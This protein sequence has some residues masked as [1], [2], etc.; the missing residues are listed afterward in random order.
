MN[1]SPEMNARCVTYT[2]L[3]I[4]F[5]HMGLPSAS[6]S[7]NMVHHTDGRRKKDLGRPQAGGREGNAILLLK[8]QTA[9]T[10][11][12]SACSLRRCPRA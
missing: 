10:K 4:C 2:S 12:L 6:D 3:T 1:K 5:I 11:E 7:Y 9:W 8:F